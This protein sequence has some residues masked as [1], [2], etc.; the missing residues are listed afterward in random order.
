MQV[1][2]IAEFPAFHYQKE[3]LRF[4]SLDTL[5]HISVITYSVRLACYSLLPYW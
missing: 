4:I 5:I 3:I 1:D 2:C